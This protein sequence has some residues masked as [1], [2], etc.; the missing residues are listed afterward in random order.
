MDTGVGRSSGQPGVTQIAPWAQA[1]VAAAWAVAWMSGRQACVCAWGV[2]STR[3]FPQSPMLSL[4]P[5]VALQFQVGYSMSR[6]QIT[7]RR[8]EL[9]R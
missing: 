7:A 3:C 2:S 4:T 9:N 5:F 8:S 6:N 1:S